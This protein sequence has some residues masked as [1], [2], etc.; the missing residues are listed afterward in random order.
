MVKDV[1]GILRKVLLISSRSPVVM[2][3]VHVC[4]NHAKIASG[5]FI[6]NAINLM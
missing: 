4:R 2:E 1:M 5:P 6:L 3:L